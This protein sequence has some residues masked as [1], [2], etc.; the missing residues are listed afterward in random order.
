MDNK[1]NK[2]LI[3]YALSG[4]QTNRFNF[5][6]P[7][8]NIPFDEV[9]VDYNINPIIKYDIKEDLILLIIN[10]KAKITGTEENILDS[11][12]TFIYHAKDLK[13]F[14]EPLEDTNTWKFKDAKDDG[15]VVAILGISIST[16]R[17]MLYEKSRGTILELKLLPIVNPASFFVK[18]NK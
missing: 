1:E 8:I 3:S 17:G 9:N 15:L 10:V 4:I 2:A 18:N 5:S 7:K 16:L 13:T 6:S 12:T 11:E 14:M